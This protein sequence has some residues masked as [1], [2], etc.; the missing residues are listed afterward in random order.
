MK[1]VKNLMLLVVIVGLVCSAYAADP[2]DNIVNNG[3]ADIKRFEGQASGL[4][5]APSA[6]AMRILKLMDLSYKRLQGSKNQGDP[7]WQE[8]NQRYV[9]LKAQLEGLMNPTKAS[10]TNSSVGNFKARSQ[11][12]HSQRQA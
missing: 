10:S 3:L 4:T 12:V 8:V 6:N 5:P 7:S 11:E 1:I 2:V 9:S